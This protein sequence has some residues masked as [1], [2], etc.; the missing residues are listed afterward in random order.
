MRPRWNCSR[1]SSSACWSASSPASATPCSTFPAAR[2]I[3]S[4]MVRALTI[5]VGLSVGFVPGADRG[6][7][8]GDYFASWDPALGAAEVGSAPDSRVAVSLAG[9]VCWPPARGRPQVR[10]CRP[11]GA[12]S[13]ARHAARERPAHPPPPPTL[14]RADRSPN[15]PSVDPKPR[16]TRR[17]HPVGVSRGPWVRRRGSR[18]VDVR[19]GA[20]HAPST[21]LDVS[22]SVADDSP[23]RWEAWRARGLFGGAWRAMDGAPRGLR[24]RLLAAVPGQPAARRAWRPYAKPSRN[25]KE[26]APAEAQIQ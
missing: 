11:R 5:R 26:A 14:R 21:R 6:V 19:A 22:L 4:K 20:L 25:A 1:S 16:A 10:P 23:Q 8:D 15:R 12:P 2:A 13:M 18:V 24:G 3:P 9:R 7:G 17:D